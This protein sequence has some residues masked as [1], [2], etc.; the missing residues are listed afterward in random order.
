MPALTVETIR[1]HMDECPCDHCGSPVYVGD[2]VY[3]DLA[4]GAAYCSRPCAAAE[5]AVSRPIP[6]AF[7]TAA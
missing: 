4:T 1:R 7:D 2:R 6:A 3:L 5:Q